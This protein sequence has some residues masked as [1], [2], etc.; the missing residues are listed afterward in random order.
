MLGLF[1]YLFVPYLSLFSV[2]LA[3]AVMGIHMKAIFPEIFKLRAERTEQEL[4][5]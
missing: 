4:S 5:R 3:P 2:F 1:S